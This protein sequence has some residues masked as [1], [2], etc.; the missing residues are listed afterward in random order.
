MQPVLYKADMIVEVMGVEWMICG[1]VL[2]HMTSPDK[3]HLYQDLT[4]QPATVD[5]IAVLY[6]SALLGHEGAEGKVTS[7]VC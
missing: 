4:G 7:E 6:H 5:W 1:F 3:L 2:P